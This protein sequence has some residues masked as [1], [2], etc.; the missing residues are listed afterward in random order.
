MLTQRPIEGFTQPDYEI[1]WKEEDGREKSVGRIF[2]TETA[3][4]K[5]VGAWFW[6]VEFHQRAGRK[7]PYQGYERSYEEA[8]EAWRKCW[9]SGNVLVKW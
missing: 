4:A 6:S 9:D 1:V 5:G 8:K 7:E 3:M 2:Y